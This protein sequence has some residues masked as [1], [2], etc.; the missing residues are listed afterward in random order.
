MQHLDT[1]DD[2]ETL[3]TLEEEK[4]SLERKTDSKR[5]ERKK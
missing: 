1:W 3:Q 4:E 2:G 5:E